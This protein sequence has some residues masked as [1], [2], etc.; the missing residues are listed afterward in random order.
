MA[1]AGLR[2]VDHLP[3]K[4]LTTSYARLYIYIDNWYSALSYRYL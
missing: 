1:P 3:W 2:T 4:C